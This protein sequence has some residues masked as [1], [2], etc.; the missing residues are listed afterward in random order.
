M[1]HVRWLMLAGALVSFAGMSRADGALSDRGRD[2]AAK[3][4]RCHAIGTADESPH[5][6][7]PPFRVLG[8][9]YPIPMLV[10]AAR[11]G[12]I[13]GHDEMPMF[14]L[15]PADTAALLTYIDGLN[16]GVAGYVRLIPR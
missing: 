2:L 13:D 4:A 14:E 16:P 12:V 5:R 11:T 1:R 15:G 6:I 7:T 3:C 8:Q 10:D 9:R